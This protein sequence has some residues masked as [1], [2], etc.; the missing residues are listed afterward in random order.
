MSVYKSFRT[1]K[2]LESAGIIIDY[3]DFK[4][5]IA[6]AGGSN[7]KFNKMIKLKVEPVKRALNVGTLPDE[8]AEEI[9]MEVYAESVVL[10]WENVTD[11]N[12]KPLKFSKENCLKLF[13]DLPD[14]FYDLKEQAEKSLLFREVVKE[15]ETKN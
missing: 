13:K 9:M 1:D 5:T 6:R 10:G 8:R 11:E 4:F 15:Q 3:G 2:N 7:K 12:D 14:L